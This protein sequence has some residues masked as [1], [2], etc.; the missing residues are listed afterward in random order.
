VTDAATAAPRQ[1][2][3]SLSFRAIQPSQLA[4]A[5][6]VDL[7]SAVSVDEQFVIVD[8]NDTAVTATELG[9]SDGRIHLIAVETG[10]F[11]VEYQAEIVPMTGAPHVRPDA[12]V[13]TAAIVALRQSRYCPSDELEGFARATFPQ[14]SPSERAHAIAEWIYLRIAYES[15]SSGPTD[16]AID[17]LL[18]HRGVCRD[19]AHLAI[20]LCRASGIPARMVAVYAPGL[21]PMDF[22]AVMEVRTEFGWE[23]LDPTRLA[24]RHSLARIAT[25]RD[26]ADIAFATTI[27]GDVALDSVEV[28]AV[29]DGDLPVDD[30][31]QVVHLG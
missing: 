2:R 19:F 26:A 11:T 25:G 23:V 1:L 15:G 20:S 30:H 29:V 22:H 27:T 31:Q 10:P 16:T 8:A 3:A 5:V 28:V 6:A 12:D 13:D 21:D 9:G 14:A 18:R 7:T 17:T 24:P 4:L